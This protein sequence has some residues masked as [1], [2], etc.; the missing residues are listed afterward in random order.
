MSKHALKCIDPATLRA[1]LAMGDTVLVDVREAAEHA[2]E[3]IAGARLM[4]LSKLDPA[5]LPGGKRVVL[6]CASGCRSRT[7]ARRLGLEGLAHLEGGL[8]A[9]IEAGMPTVSN[10]MLR[11]SAT[12]VF[13]HPTQ[14]A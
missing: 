14:L 12:R 3:R 6:C 7:A 11:P 2:R 10:E 1:W 9:W 8:S 13:G 5:A 4:P